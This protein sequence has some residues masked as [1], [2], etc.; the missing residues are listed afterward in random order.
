[1]KKQVLALSLSVVMAVSALAGC[2]SKSEKETTAAGTKAAEETKA[3]ETKA[4][5]SKETKAAAS[6]DFKGTIKSVSYTHLVHHP[7]LHR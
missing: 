2:G 1:M 5:D 3:G 4:N 7:R 6:G